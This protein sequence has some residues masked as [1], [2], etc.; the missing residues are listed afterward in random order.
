[1]DKINIIKYGL[2]IDKKI[3]DNCQLSL[4]NKD[5][6]EN[7]N[8]PSLIKVPDFVPNPLGKY[9]LYFGHHKGKYI[10][11]A[12]SNNIIGPYTL[13]SPGVLHLK[14]TPGYDHMAS[15]DVIVDEENKRIILYYHCKFDNSITPQSTFYAYST[16]GLD[17][18]SENNN[19]LH[20]YFRYFR[21]MDCEYGIA[22]YKHIGS[23]I[24]KKNNNKYEEFGQ[25][26][27]KSRHTSILLINSKIYI[28]YTIVGDCP[29]HIYFCQITNFEKNN[30]KTSDPVS[31]IKP[32][33][34]F[35]HND[36][37]PIVSKYG[38]VYEKINQLRD[39][40][41]FVDNNEFYIFYTVCGEKGI[42]VCKIENL[43]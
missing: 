23:I 19:I 27:P 9:Y 33:F 16:N 17:F 20:P 36:Q 37:K 7:I 34:T 8:G 14:D 28:F 15:P 30:L 2:V 41:V 5:I 43:L 39:P 38:P 25:L 40:Y 21:Y 4:I 35:E 29:E 32:E 42:A 13:Y 3:F 1:M 18:V 31:I 12:Y 11:M 26:L 24:L 6:S 10:R 22:M